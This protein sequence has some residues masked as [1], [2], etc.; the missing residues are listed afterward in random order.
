MAELP[1]Q[2][3]LP[4]VDGV[5]LE[6][7]WWRSEPTGDRNAAVV[8]GHPSGGDA[9]LIA[10]M[11]MAL[12]DAGYHAVAVSMR[13]FGRSGGADDGGLRQ[14]DDQLAVVRWLVQQP[15]ID[16]SRIALWGR[17][18]GGQVAL[19]A[20]SRAH[21]L[22]RAVAVWNAVTDIDHWRA[23]S[24]HPGI[25]GYIDRC[26]SPDTRA[27]SPA[28]HAQEIAVPVLLVHGAIDTR[29]PT[30]QSVMMADRLREAGTHVDLELLEGLGHRY[31]PDGNA[32]ALALTL[33]F[34]A[35]HL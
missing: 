24:A 11:A 28:E 3:V 19:L 4:G 13:G 18:H 14:P 34:L 12:R 5:E 26:C 30:S 21:G 16:P 31:G 2:L 22:V 10:P 15:E 35:R 1:D 29:V 8:L 9:H 23:H 25:D 17:S 33:E 7:V 6:A 32:R 27:R 20:A